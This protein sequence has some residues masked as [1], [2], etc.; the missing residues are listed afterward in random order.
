[1]EARNPEWGD[2]AHTY[3]NL[4]IDHPAY[5]WI[6]FTATPNDVE[7]HGR[8]IFAAALAGDYGPVLPWAPP[9]LTEE[10]QLDQYER[11]LDAFLDATAQ[12]LTFKDRHSLALRA[13]YPNPWRTLGQAF[14]EWMDTCNALAWAGRQ[15]I[16]AGTKPMPANKEEFLAELPAFV[17]PD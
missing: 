10:E 11:D 7:A 6:P 13:G 2:P 17:A 5:G 12:A 9:G 8:E 4:E 15:A 3:I 16:L 1:M 14:G